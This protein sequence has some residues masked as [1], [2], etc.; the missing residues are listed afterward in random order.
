MLLSFYGDDFTGSTDVMEALTGNGIPSA[1]FLS[2]PSQEELAGFRLIQRIGSS[3]GSIQAFG[4]PGIARSLSPE[5]MR[6]QLPPIFRQLATIK[7]RFFHYKTCSTFDS[8]PEVGNIAVATDLAL[9]HF[10][11]SFIP[12]VVAAPS[13]GRYSVFGNLFARVGEATYRL[14][15]HPTMSRHPVTPMKESD[16][17][18][19]LAAQGERRCELIDIF[20]L[21]EEA[22]S[23][24]AAISK[25]AGAES[26]FVLFDCLDEAS[27]QRVGEIIVRSGQPSGQLLVGS[28]GIEYALCSHLRQEGEIPVRPDFPSPGPA[29]QMV[30]LSGSAA[31]ASG[32]QIAHG[33]RI[34]FADIRIQTL[35]LIDDSSREQ[36]IG[37]VC[38]LAKAALADGCSPLIYAA[39]GPDDP[40]LA[41]TQEA[42]RRGG[43]AAPVGQRIASAQGEIL[44]RVLEGARPTRAV[45]A[46]GDTSGYAA[47]A[48]KLKALEMLMPVAPGAPL[49]VAHSERENF[50]GLQICLKGGQ[51]GNSRFYESILRGQAL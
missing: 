11:S 26:P 48:L 47:Q 20:L 2:P 31:P 6:Q 46:G 1:L 39:I 3:D 17:R 4:V 14:D 42:A 19:H 18:R 28:S 50:H 40:A 49:C 30:V 32:E 38:Q 24:I 36:E 23:A 7:S 21:R 9:R 5:Q 41:R 45:V 33:L 35:D 12:L 25:L 51:N 34:G 43:L 15:R 27:L 44:R 13:L 37:R 10:P 16:L 8:S 22:A 29:D